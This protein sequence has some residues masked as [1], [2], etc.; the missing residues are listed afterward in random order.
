MKDVQNVTEFL[1]RF[2]RRNEVDSNINPIIRPLQMVL[3]HCQ[4][5][6]KPFLTTNYQQLFMTSGHFWA[7]KFLPQIRECA[8]KTQAP[9]HELMK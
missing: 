9:L 8:S 2:V 4:K 6:L 5:K 7:D 1:S 3:A